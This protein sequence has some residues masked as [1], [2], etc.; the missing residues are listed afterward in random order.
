MIEPPKPKTTPAK[1]TKPAAAPAAQKK[2]AKAQTSRK[3]S[4]DDDDDDFD[5]SEKDDAKEMGDVDDGKNQTTTLNQ[6]IKKD[7]ENKEAKANQKTDNK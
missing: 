4:D 5:V 2:T 3:N 6:V 1:T 7:L